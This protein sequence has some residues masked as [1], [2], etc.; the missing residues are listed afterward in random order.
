VRY[1]YSQKNGRAEKQAVIYSQDEHHIQFSDIDGSAFS[2]CSM[3]Q[4]V[5]YE[6][7]IVGGAVRDLLLK[8]KPKDFDI[9]TEARPP[10][11]KRVI[12]NSRLIGRRF[13]LVHVFF[14]QKI[15]EVST[16]R[17]IK[18]GTI[19]NTFGKIEEDVMRRDFT[20]NALFYD[21]VKQLLLDYVG[22]VNDIRAKTV[23]PII[24][25]GVIFKEDP[26][27]MI[28]AVKYC[29]MAGWTLPAAL[30]SKI[31]SQAPLLE[32]VSPS[33]LTEEITKIIK[34]SSAPEIIKSLEDLNLFKYLQPA[35]SAL[36]KSDK[37]FAEKYFTSLAAPTEGK[38]KDGRVVS[39][40]NGLIEDYL[41]LA[42]DWSLF[43][44]KTAQD[45]YKETFKKIRAFIQPMNPPRAELE[46]A[47]RAIFTKQGLTVKKLRLQSRFSMRRGSRLVKNENQKDQ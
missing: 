16:F 10:E 19:G 37:A 22:G 2:V 26:V 13:K 6:T 35:A 21:P 43:T 7:Y 1:R 25:A 47:I 27:R 5:G 3:L 42:T 15:I 28:R 30:Y 17:S 20:M 41:E 12:R 34:S 18:D 11:I 9:A 31:R 32:T 23:K 44:E 45:F 29:A 4:K 39:Y 14:G 24:P 46:G 38:E 8:R 33:R 40:L 36:I